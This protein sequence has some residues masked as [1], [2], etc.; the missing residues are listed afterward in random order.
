MCHRYEKLQH[1]KKKKRFWISS[2][3]N[4]C[5]LQEFLKRFQYY[6]E[7]IHSHPEQFSSVFFN[8]FCELLCY[9]SSYF[10]YK[11]QLLSSYSA[12]FL[13]NT[14]VQSDFFVSL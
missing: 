5:N 14:L 6:S 4:S 3:P 1:L 12:I 11:F 10:M 8:N 13:T 7:T 9:C 2:Q